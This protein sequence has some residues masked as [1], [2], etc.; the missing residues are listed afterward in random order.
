MTAWYATIAIAGVLALAWACRGRVFN[1]HPVALGACPAIVVALAAASCYALRLPE[2]DAVGD[3]AA[4]TLPVGLFTLHLA[5]S[6][7]TSE[8][9]AGVTRPLLATL[10]AGVLLALMVVAGRLSLLDA[11][12]LLAAGAV[13]VLIVDTGRTRDDESAGLVLA[14]MASMVVGA[15]LWVVVWRVFG[16]G[17]LWLSVGAMV[18]M[19]AF[20]I[21][22]TGAGAVHAHAS[23]VVTSMSVAL[24]GGSLGALWLA[25]VRNLGE[26]RPNG[27]MATLKVLAMS[28]GTCP[29]LIGLNRLAPE[30]ALLIAGPA[31]A[32]SSAES[33]VRRAM[34]WMLA[35]GAVFVMGNRFLR[36]I[37]APAL[38]F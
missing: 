32:L 14:M 22:G 11:Q 26:L 27:A 21:R 1:G 34:A 15:M 38:L 31:A 25:I 2:T 23:L 17:M 8:S 19:A 6:M 28:V 9:F 36:A 3:F 33:G 13:L 35:L 16:S 12:L 30:A 10:A 4:I 37:G 20:G 18:A 5:R 7:A 29:P 24:A